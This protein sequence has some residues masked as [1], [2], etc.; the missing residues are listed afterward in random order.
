MIYATT[1]LALG[2]LAGHGVLTPQQ[3]APTVVMGTVSAKRS[4]APPTDRSGPRPRLCSCAG[5]RGRLWEEAARLSAIL[6]FA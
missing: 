5:E 4:N 2:F 1:A 3:N 6:L